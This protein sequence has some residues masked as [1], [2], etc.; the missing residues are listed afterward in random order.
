MQVI[1]RAIAKICN[2]EEANLGLRMIVYGLTE[3]PLTN[4]LVPQILISKS[5]PFFDFCESAYCAAAISFCKII[6][7]QNLLTLSGNFV[8][9]YDRGVFYAKKRSFIYCTNSRKL[10]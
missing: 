8:T 5:H 1:T 3:V 4:R 6:W 10:F 9:Q 2:A 7:E